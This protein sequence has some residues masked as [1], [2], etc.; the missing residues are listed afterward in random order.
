MAPPGRAPAASACEPNRKIIEQAG[1]R[2]R[3]AV[4]IYQALVSDTVSRRSTPATAGSYPGYEDARRGKFES[5]PLGWHLSRLAAMA[6][7][8]KR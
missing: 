1:S 5:S 3:N 2:G 7:R 4:A 6:L 8:C